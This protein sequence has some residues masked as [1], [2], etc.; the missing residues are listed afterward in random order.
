MN[1]QR[2]EGDAEM[3]KSEQ[4][5]EFTKQD[6]EA[7]VA[8][9]RAHKKSK[10]QIEQIDKQI[11]ELNSS[12]SESTVDLDKLSLS[13]YS[14]MEQPLATRDTGVVK[15]SK[16]LAKEEL[17]EVPNNS[18]N[19]NNNNNNNDNNNSEFQKKKEQNIVEP[20]LPSKGCLK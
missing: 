7:E 8:S 6:T 2:T 3:N 10:Q 18:S 13:S 9:K 14:S 17:L 15:A 1:K 19:N 4:I 11:L 16:T 12:E 20:P 5:E